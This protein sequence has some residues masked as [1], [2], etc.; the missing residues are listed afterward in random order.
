[1]DTTSKPKAV[2]GPDDLLLMLIHHWARDESVFP[3]ED[4]RHDVATVMLFQAYTGGRPAEFVHSSRGKA[5]DDPLDEREETT[6]DE[7]VLEVAQPGYND[8]GDADD[9]SDA[10]DG[11]EFDNEVL[12]DSDEEED[13]DMDERCGEDSGYA[14]DNA[15]VTIA[16]DTDK[17]RPT[18]LYESEEPLP[19]TLDPAQRSEPEEVK[20][21]CK[22][23][24]CEDI[25]L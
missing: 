14:S 24:C 2:A 1:M 10:V 3:I 19:Q 8:D 25:C 15:D 6:T 23:L 20:R 17:C 5:G 4:D 22:A 13:D 18:K 21:K 9:N 7:R 16:E 11:T 12:F